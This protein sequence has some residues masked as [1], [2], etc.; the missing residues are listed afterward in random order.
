MY[1]VFYEISRPRLY[2]KAGY[3]SCLGSVHP[4]MVDFG[5][6]QGPS[7]FSTSPKTSRDLLYGWTPGN[8]SFTIFQVSSGSKIFI[9]SAIRVVSLPRSFS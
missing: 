8:V 3:L 1:V 5:F 7:E 4:E 6:R 9:S 2:G